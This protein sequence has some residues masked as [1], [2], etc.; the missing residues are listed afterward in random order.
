M[1]KW[2]VICVISSSN[3]T[4]IMALFDANSGVF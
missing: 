4:Q 1:V 3:L 2:F